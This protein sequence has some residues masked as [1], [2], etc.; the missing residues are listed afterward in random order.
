MSQQ[1]TPSVEC[2]DLER[3]LGGIDPAFRPLLDGIDYRFEHESTNRALLDAGPPPPGRMH[4]ALAEYQSA[5]R[6]RHGRR[7][8]MPPGAGIALSASWVFETRPDSLNALSLA[9]GAAVRRAVQSVTGI[10]IE[11]KWPND[12]LIDGGKLGGILVELAA[13]NASAVHVVIGVGLNV[14]VPAAVLAAASDYAAGARDLRGCGWDPVDRSA[15]AGALLGRFAELF[16]GFADS[17]FAP[18]RQEWLAA[19]ALNGR[20]VQLS[21]HGQTESGRVVGIEADGALILAMPGGEQ[22]RV[23]SGEVSVRAED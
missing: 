16:A 7:W 22:R 12:L 3:V 21:S 20:D 19:H 15:L 1:S 4:A 23:V 13:G 2:L 11:L 10:A 8:T 17:G 14:D 18:Y 6:G 5:G 9:A